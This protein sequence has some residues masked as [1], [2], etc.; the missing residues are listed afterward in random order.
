VA[1]LP[2]LIDAEEAIQ[3]YKAQPSLTDAAKA[4]AIGLISNDG[5]SNSEIREALEIDK[6]YA[7]THLKRA[8]TQLSLDEL[9]LWHNNPSKNTLGH[10]RAIAKL[11]REKREPLLRN[12]LANKCSVAEYEA[13]GR[14]RETD[15]DVDI[16]RF[17]QLMSER[18]GRDIKIQYNKGKQYGRITLGFFTLDDLD[19]ITEKLGYSPELD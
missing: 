18:L 3:F 8:G 9:E 17:E 19:D 2:L 14:G 15:K 16:K 1:H 12:L 6:V 13:I 7:V 11:N 5:Y 4:Y 10:V